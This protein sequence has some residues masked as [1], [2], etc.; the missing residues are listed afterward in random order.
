M[1]MSEPHDPI[2]H[3]PTANVPPADETGTHLTITAGNEP[4]AAVRADVLADMLAE[5]RDGLSRAQK[6]IPSRY[7]YDARGSALFEEITRLP[8]YYLTRA[9]RE[10]L[11]AWM[12]AWAARLRVRTVVELGAGSAAKTR[13]I[14]DALRATGRLAAYVPVDVSA[15][16]LCDSARAL[17]AEYPGLRVRPVAGD[18]TRRIHLPRTV[19]APVLV[20]FLGSTIGNFAPPDDTALL[21]RVA[22]QMRVGDHLLLGTDLRKDPAVLEAAYDDP[23]GVTAEFNRN[24]LRVV[25]DVHGADFDVESFRHRAFYDRELHRIEMHLVAERDMTVHL[26]RAGDVH[27][28]RGESI[29]TEVSRKFD[30]GAVGALLD[31]AGLR[32][33][34]WAT[35]SAG[36]FALSLATVSDVA[37]ETPVARAD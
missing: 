7:F 34:D 3:V 18:F 25:N 17:R 14:L 10:I 4:A 27:I 19:P 16:F 36:L 32:L 11:A 29:R 15:E 1:T 21:A 20:A 37:R 30:R 23:R 5:L 26:P 9:E 28:R 6:E 13:I 31:A 2:S 22:R 35:D 12:P 8:E 33:V 24:A